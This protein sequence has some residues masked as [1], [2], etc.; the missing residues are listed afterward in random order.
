MSNGAKFQN[1]TPE[2]SVVNVY[3]DPRPVAPAENLPDVLAEEQ[4]RAEAQA[5]AVET[6]VG[7]GLTTDQAIVVVSGLT[8]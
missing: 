5:A 7:L 8:A 6:L 4:A 3:L 2:G 1:I